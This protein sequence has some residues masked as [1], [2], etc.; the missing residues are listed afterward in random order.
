MK[1]LVKS[2][3]VFAIMLLSISINAQIKNVKKATV[4]ISGNCGMCKKNIEKA[5]SKNNIAKVIWNEKSKM[6]TITY[7]AKKTNT[8]KILKQIAL[9][10]YDSDNFSAPDDSYNNLHECCKYDRKKL[11]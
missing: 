2:L 10:G 11:K 8:N 1:N 7:D 9:A 4:N 6:A 5:G 3:L